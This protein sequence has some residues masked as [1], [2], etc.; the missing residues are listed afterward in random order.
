MSKSKL[1]LQSSIKNVSTVIG[2]IEEG[3]ATVLHPAA[4]SGRLRR[5]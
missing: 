3:L 5:Q 1:A 4:R 2:K